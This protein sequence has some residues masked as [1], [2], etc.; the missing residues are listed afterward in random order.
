MSTQAARHELHD[1]APTHLGARHEAD[2]SDSTVSY[3]RYRLV[4]N[5]LERPIGIERGR[6]VAAD[7]AH[8]MPAFNV[9]QYFGSQPTIFADYDHVVTARSVETGR[10]VSLIG[11]RW[12]GTEELRFL[13]LWT[14]MVADDYRATGVFRRS[15]AHF[16]ERVA[17]STAG[18]G[19]PALI[20]TKTYNPVVYKI[21]SM[22]AAGARNV[23]LYPMIPATEQPPYMTDLARRVAHAIS[24]KLQLVTES[25]VVR[26][27]QAMVAPDFFPLMEQ[28]K[29][30]HVNAH[31]ERHLSRSD[32]ILCIARIPDTARAEVLQTLVS[33]HVERATTLQDSGHH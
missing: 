12:L 6:V 19:M 24:P 21:F 2:D 11:A 23:E 10:I 16:F 26:G 20:V 22:F 25:G 17:A 4:H 29:D 28:S 1:S 33:G 14:A 15:L 32:Q 18:L 9:A 27:G 5:T 3:A 13:Y 31:F 8:G 30:A 7:L